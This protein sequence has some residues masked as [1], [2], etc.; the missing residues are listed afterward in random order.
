V[1]ALKHLS[2]T[3]WRIAGRHNEESFRVSTR[4]TSGPTRKSATSQ[5]SVERQSSVHQNGAAQS[6]IDSFVPIYSARENLVPSGTLEGGCFCGAI[7]YSIS[8]EP[9]GSMICHCR[10]CRRLSAAP[11]VA[12]LTV[13]A[14]DFR[15]TKGEPNTFRSSS[16]VLRS[17]CSNCGTHVSYL[18]KSEPLYVEVSTCSLDD[19][20]AYPPTHHSWLEHDIAWVKFGDRLP[21]YPNSRYGSD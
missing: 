4:P 15:I 16:H 18:H 13:A 9:S 2:F 8:A 5:R 14:H 17:L 19:P 7:R 6:R 20:A 12:W 21:T 11:A 3:S 10:T 1:V